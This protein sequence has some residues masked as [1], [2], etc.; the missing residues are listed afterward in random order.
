MSSPTSQ[1][2]IHKH[3]LTWIAL[4]IALLVTAAAAAAPI[5]GWL[6]F[7]ERRTLSHVALVVIALAMLTVAL[8]FRDWTR[9]VLRRFFYAVERPLNLAIYRVVLFGTIFFDLDDDASRRVVTFFAELPRD[10]RSRRR[11]WARC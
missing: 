11:A 1:P 5:V 10:C 4:L 3:P 2:A 7:G 9:G 6:T 8:Y